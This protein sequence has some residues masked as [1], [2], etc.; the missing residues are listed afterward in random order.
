MSTESLD[1]VIPRTVAV[2]PGRVRGNQSSR[3]RA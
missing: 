2:I 1:P 3:Y